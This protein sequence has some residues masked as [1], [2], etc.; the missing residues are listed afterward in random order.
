MPNSALYEI[1]EVMFNNFSGSTFRMIDITECISVLL[2]VKCM[3]RHALECLHP[4]NKCAVR[5]ISIFPTRNIDISL[6]T[7]FFIKFQEKSLVYMASQDAKFDI[8]ELF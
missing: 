4:G 7:E 2:Y 6:T 3:S 1:H 8:P 5:E